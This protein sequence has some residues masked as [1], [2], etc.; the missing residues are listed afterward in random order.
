MKK[1]G[2][3]SF[4]TLATQFVSA[5]TKITDLSQPALNGHVKQVI[6][7]VFRGNDDIDTLKNSEK[8]ILYFD[9][10]GNQL[11]EIDF[12]K[13]GEMQ[14]VFMFKYQGDT[15]VTKNQFYKN[16]LS[17]K[18]VYKYD[19]LGNE[20]EFDTYSY[21]QNIVPQKIYIKYR[22]DNSKKRIAEDTYINDRL[23][24]TDT[25]IYNDKD[26]KTEVDSY[27]NAFLSQKIKYQYDPQGNETGFNNYNA[28]GVL[29]NSNEILYNG[30]DTQG[31]W[32]MITSVYKGFGKSPQENYLNKTIKKRTITYY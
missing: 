20:I 9:E 25:L 1:L 26:Q 17:G 28:N 27:S 15:V 5:Q 3:F 24:T 11:R 2:L 31:N 4:L 14:A 16:E 22:Y 32:T 12:D 21:S 8:N 29:V 19:T 7:Y 18:Y 23:T 13:E 30:F 10:K 6:E